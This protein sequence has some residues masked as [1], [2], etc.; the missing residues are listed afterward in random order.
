[1]RGDPDFRQT[2]P[3]DRWDNRPQG[4]FLFGIDAMP[5]LVTIAKGLPEGLWKPPDRPAPDEVRTEP[6]QRPSNVKERI[7]QERG[8][9][10]VHRPSAQMAEFDYRPTKCQKTYRMVALRQNPSGEQGPQRLFDEI[11]YFFD[12]PDGRTPS[13]AEIVPLA[14]ERC[15][16]ENR[17][18][19]LKNG[20][21]AMR[22]PVDNLVSNWAYLVM[23]SLAWTLK[24]WFALLLPAQGRWAD[25]YAAAGSKNNLKPYP[26]AADRREQGEYTATRNRLSIPQGL[27]L[28][29]C[30]RTSPSYTVR[31][32]N[33]PS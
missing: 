10:N 16:P 7:V 11:R 27:G 5:N 4:R 21:R 30:V 2:E 9:K 23:A 33:R 22:M 12:S 19:P 15:N 28:F 24:A 8:Y 20:V 13:A 32:V 1:L 31:R 17:I 14:N 6:R 29:A 18:E 3:W 26:Q 25:Q